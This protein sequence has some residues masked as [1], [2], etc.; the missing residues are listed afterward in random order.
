MKEATSKDIELSRIIS[1]VQSGW[2]QVG[3]KAEIQPYYNRRYELYCEYG[4]LMWGY[5]MIIPARLREL[6]LKQLHNSHMGIVKI[7]ALARSY[8]WWPNIDADIEDVCKRCETCAA[9]A[10]APTRAPPQPWPYTAQPWTRLH[11]DF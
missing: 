7:K 9:E 8:V 2:P 1:Y 4:C 11:V 10:D 6:I 3:S 5:R